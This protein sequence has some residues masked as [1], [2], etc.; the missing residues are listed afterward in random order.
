MVCDDPKREGP[1]KLV[2][3]RALIVDRRDDEYSRKLVLTTIP[4]WDEPNRFHRSR[5]A[6]PQNREKDATVDCGGL[7]EEEDRRNDEF[8][9]EKDR[10]ERERESRREVRR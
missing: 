2:H 7:D 9:A 5:F 4:N 8:V 6:V 10:S 3:R 1:D